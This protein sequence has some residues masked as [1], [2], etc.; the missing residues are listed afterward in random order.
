MQTT[1]T[2]TEII[3]AIKNGELF[4]T[5]VNPNEEPETAE[6]G[7]NI[8]R[9]GVSF[10][11]YNVDEIMEM[12]GTIINIMREAKRGTENKNKKKEKTR[13]GFAPAD[14][15]SELVIDDDSWDF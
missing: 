15:E 1:M 13:I 4:L 8:S 2:D 10:A 12:E 3:R 9:K 7:I 14:V 5:T 6:M 11:G